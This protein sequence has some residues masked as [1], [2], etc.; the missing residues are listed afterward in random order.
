MNAFAQHEPGVGNVQILME[1]G[2][3]CGSNTMVWPKNL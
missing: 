1:F 3:T 2:A